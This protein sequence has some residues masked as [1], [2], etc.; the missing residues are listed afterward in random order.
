MWG[1]GEKTWKTSV[2]REVGWSGGTLLKQRVFS[3]VC[4]L[5]CLLACLFIYLSIYLFVC[6]FVC[7]FIYLLAY[8]LTYSLIHL[9]SLTHSLTHFLPYSLPCF[10]PYSHNERNRQKISLHKEQNQTCG[11][12]GC[13]EVFWGKTSQA[14]YDINLLTRHIILG[15]DE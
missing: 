10:L 7:L 2:G 3:L 15:W 5:A 8:L 6:L 9:S 4:L 13:G 12:C 14:V 1:G 11:R